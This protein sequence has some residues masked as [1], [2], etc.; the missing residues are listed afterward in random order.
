[1]LDAA[2]I[3]WGASGR[4]GGIVGFGSYKRSD[5]AMIHAFGQDEMNRYHEELRQGIARA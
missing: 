4:N 5:E 3:G 2:E 1:M